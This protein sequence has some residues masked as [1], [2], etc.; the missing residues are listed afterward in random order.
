MTAV[1]SE[2]TQQERAEARPERSMLFPIEGIDLSA[3]VAT[4]EQIG[5]LN[6]HRHEM[7]LIDRVVWVDEGFHSGVAA[8]D[9]R[10]DE[11]WVRG[12]FP[13]RPM[14]PGVLMVEAGAQLACY[15]YNK[16]HGSSQ[17]AAFLRIEDAV[18]RRSV[19]PGETLLILC[20]EVKRSARRFISD[21]QGVCGGQVTFEARIH[22]MRL[23]SSRGR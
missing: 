9:V 16:H 22:G 19:E 20:R 21:V 12:H 6:P 5:E 1:R 13:D 15:L 23:D 10:D 7:A 18:F 11:F 8:W 17:L 14:L 3:V 4:R 2:S